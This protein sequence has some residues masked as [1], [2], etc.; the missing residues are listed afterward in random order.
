MPRPPLPSDLY[1][2][3][4]PTEVRLSPDGSHVVFTTK[5]I[6]PGK[7]DYRDA[8]WIAP[9]DGSAPARQITLGSKHDTRPRWSPDGTVLAFLSDRGRVLRAGGGS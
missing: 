8:I 9:A 5:A 7:D 2:L 3:R 6:G 4:I 1:D